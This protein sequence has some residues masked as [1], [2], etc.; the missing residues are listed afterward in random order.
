M[1][2]LSKSA[3][4]LI[5]YCAADK[6]ICPIADKWQ[7]LWK[8]LPEDLTKEGRDKTAPLPLILAAIECEPWEK[9]MRVKNHIEWADAHGVI[10]QVDLFLRSLSTEEWEQQTS[11]YIKDNFYDECSFKYCIDNDDVEGMKI[12]LSNGVNPND[13]YSDYSKGN[14]LVR[15][16][17][18]GAINA[19][20]YLLSIH[21]ELDAASLSAAVVREHNDILNL[22]LDSGVVPNADALCS[23][24]GT[25]NIQG[26][27][28]LLLAGAPIN[29][30]TSF[31]W[32]ALHNAVI[33]DQTEIVELLLKSEANSNVAT[34]DG[35]TPLMIAV[36]GGDIA[37]VELLLKYGANP[38][39]RNDNGETALDIARENNQQKVI[40]ILESLLSK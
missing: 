39:C 26:V 25:N 21:V 40:S 10:S 35:T 11:N 24:A 34:Q 17:E 23:A 28:R 13:I 15:A 8:M 9:R 29:D 14:A 16:A 6:R 33:E 30:V 4:S 18:E 38:L 19:V 1:N 20:A 12:Y 32:Y 3:E 27:E 36:S 5:E 37:I 31:G 7:E 2:Q 22:L